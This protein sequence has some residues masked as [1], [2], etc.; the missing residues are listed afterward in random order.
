VLSSFILDIFSHISATK[1]NYKKP[2]PPKIFVD[3]GISSKVK[4]NN[5]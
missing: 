4:L 2:R 3:A 1:A 5:P